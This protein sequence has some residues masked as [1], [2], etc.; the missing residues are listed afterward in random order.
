[1]YVNLGKTKVMDFLSLC[2]KKKNTEKSFISTRGSTTQLKVSG[3]VR[4]PVVHSITPMPINKVPIQ[5]VLDDEE[6]QEWVDMPSEHLSWMDAQERKQLVDYRLDQAAIASI[7]NHGNYKTWTYD[8]EDYHL[9]LK[10]D[11]YHVTWQ[12]KNREHYFFKGTGEDIQN[13]QPTKQERGQHAHVF[14]DLPVNLQN[15][16]KKHFFE[17][18]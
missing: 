2:T 10:Y 7:N 4:K 13:K 16:I 1:M 18:L 8:G 15:F 11:T 6:L 12:S 3:G 5:R 9:N 14:S 17:L